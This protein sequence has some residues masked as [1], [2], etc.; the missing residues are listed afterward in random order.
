MKCL[1]PTNMKISVQKYTSEAR[2]NTGFSVPNCFVL[3][4][5]LVSTTS[6]SQFWIWLC[7][8]AKLSPGLGFG[9]H[10]VI[11]FSP[12]FGTD[13]IFVILCTLVCVQF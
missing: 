7:Q 9:F 4:L 3:D 5:V 11:L 10:F 12:R 2:G 1:R 8:E 13:L 6:E